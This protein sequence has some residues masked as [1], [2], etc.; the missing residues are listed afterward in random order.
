M[1]KLVL[2]EYGRLSIRVSD[3]ERKVYDEKYDYNVRHCA[4]WGDYRDRILEYF[5]YD[6]SAPNPKEDIIIADNI[7][8]FICRI[9]YNLVVYFGDDTPILKG[10]M[11]KTKT[12][13]FVEWTHEDYKR[14]EYETYYFVQ[15]QHPEK[16]F[17]VN[18]YKYDYEFDYWKGAEEVFVNLNQYICRFDMSKDELKKRLADKAKAER[19]RKRKEKERERKLEIL[20][21]TP[22]YCCRCG[23][24]HAELCVNPFEEEMNGII[25]HEW[26]CADCYNDIAGDI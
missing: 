13:H 25:V 14:K 22:G 3:D 17:I 26:L 2:S 18:R 10:K 21:E 5:G 12:P 15:V 20:K 9:N 7:N 11:I 23:A 16:M 6:T 1:A 8:P 4:I 19:E 24:A